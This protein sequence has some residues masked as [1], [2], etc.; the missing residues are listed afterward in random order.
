MTAASVNGGRGMKAGQLV[1]EQACMPD[2]WTRAYRECRWTAHRNHE[3]DDIE[4]EYSLC[5][6]LL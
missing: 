4:L 2:I 6:S 3:Y 1:L 5:T